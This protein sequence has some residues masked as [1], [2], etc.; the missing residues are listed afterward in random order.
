MRY[1]VTYDSKISNYRLVDIFNEFAKK[2]RFFQKEMAVIER[3]RERETAGERN[4]VDPKF[5]EKIRLGIEF[6]P[7]LYEKINRSIDFSYLSNL[8]DWILLF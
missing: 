1:V 3:E 4:K 8:I 6:I 2:S 5:M 7:Q